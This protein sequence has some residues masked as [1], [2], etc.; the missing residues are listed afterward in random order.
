VRK[1][2]EVASAFNTDKGSWPGYLEVYERHLTDLRAA[3]DAAVLLELGIKDGGSLQLW[4]DYLPN[5][6]IIGLDLELPPLTDPSGRIR[7]YRGSQDDEALLRRIAATEAPGGF[8]VIIDDCA[9]VGALALESFRVLYPLLRPG[10]LYFIEDW[11]AGYWPDW[12]DGSRARRA[13]ASPL[14]SFV[15]RLEAPLHRASRAT[16]RVPRPVRALVDRV[17]A[18]EQAMVW[19]QPTAGMVGFVKLLVDEVGAVDV[20]RGGGTP[21]LGANIEEL[22]IRPGVVVVK[23]PSTAR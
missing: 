15:R 7:M 11:G 17:R 8:D 9:H 12:I 14:A 19:R 13:A 5:A 20:A 22:T 23:K 18:T 6:R 1:I 21:A 2:E 16:G 4:R 10:G 3:P